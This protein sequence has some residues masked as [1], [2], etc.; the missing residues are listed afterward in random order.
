ME[1]R[2]LEAHWRHQRERQRREAEWADLWHDGSVLVDGVAIP[3]RQ[4]MHSDAGVAVVTFDLD[5]QPVMVV[6]EGMA[7]GSLRLVGVADPIPLLDEMETRRRRVF[8]QT[9][10]GPRA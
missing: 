2:M 8:A 3:A 6:A 7:L 5:G 10:D 9:T 1:R 4:L